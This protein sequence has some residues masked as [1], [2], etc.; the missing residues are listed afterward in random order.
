MA[1]SL[2]IK[3]GKLNTH[4]NEQAKHK[5]ILLIGSSVDRFAL[6]FYC[7]HVEG[8]GYADAK[9]TGTLD[10]GL[11]LP[12]GCSTESF[13]V[14][15]MFIPG[16]GPPPYFQCDHKPTLCGD[17]SLLSPGMT[18]ARPN[19]IIEIDAPD[20][21]A[22][23]F[24]GSSPD[25]VVVESSNWDVTAWH[26][27]EGLGNSVVWPPSVLEKHIKQWSDHDVPA[28][29]DLAQK[30][31]PDSKILTH[32]PARVYT[33]C[34]W[35]QSPEAFDNL[36][37]AL[38]SK[39]DE[40]GLLYGKYAYIDYY[41]IIAD[42]LRAKEAAGINPFESYNTYHDYKHPGREPAVKYIDE[43]LALA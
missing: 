42:I 28:L 16:S 41:K 5:N 27:D 31:F 2:Q 39:A 38:L 18:H 10:E 7:E 24:N 4:L 3:G 23:N 11:Q 14:A 32:T 22:R 6:N 19:E 29:L 34:E 35:G 26:V 25:I 21:V 1:S 36:T 33:D 37:S 40:N 17:N 30:A 15:Y 9:F 12:Q 8:T 13:T 20:F 43:L